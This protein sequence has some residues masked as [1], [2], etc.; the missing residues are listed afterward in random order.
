[1]KSQSAESTVP[2]TRRNLRPVAGGAQGLAPVQGLGMGRNQTPGS[3]RRRATG[4][5]LL[6]V[7]L[8]VLLW[9]WPVEAAAAGESAWGWWGTLGRWL[10]LIILLWIIVYLARAPIARYFEERRRTIQRDLVAAREARQRAE[11]MLA[12]IEEKV[13][14]LD[15]ELAEIRA[16]ARR[17]G[18]LERERVVREAELDAGKIVGAVNREIEIMT[19]TAQVRLNEYAANL[20]VRLAEELVRRQMG[21]KD[22]ERVRTRFF[23]TLQSQARI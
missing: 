20:T 9:P 22:E 4:V 11:K 2:E 10:N 19:R 3:R 18:N 12:E 23:K 17:E 16:Q 6:L 8:A 5:G 14:D 21:P 1:M 7:L 15:R 13:N